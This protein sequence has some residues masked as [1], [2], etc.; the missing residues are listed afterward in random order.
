M[1]ELLKILIVFVFLLLLI[2]KKIP[3]GYTLLL[4]A[5]F[6]GILFSLPVLVLIENLFKATIEWETLRLLFIVILVTIF[7][8]VLRYTRSLRDLTD[9]LESLIQDTRVILMLLPALI[10]ILPMPG[11]AMMSA[12]MVEE[13]GSRKKL[14]PEIKAAFNHWFRHILEFVFPLYQGVIIAS[15]ILKVPLSKIILA[16][17]PMSLT[18]LGAGMV[19]LFCKIKVEKE[20]DKI[21]KK[22]EENLFLFLKSI[23]GVLLAVILNLFLG[24]DLLWALLLSISFF[25]I[26]NRIKLSAFFKIIRENVTWD[27]VMLIL[28]IM[29]FKKIIEVSGAVTVVPQ[30]LSTWGVSPVLVICLVPFA[31]GALTGVTTAF[32]GISYPIL[33]SF[34]KPDGVHFGYAML[35]YAAGFTGVMLSPVHLCLVL[36]KDYF[37]ASFSKIY[38]LIIPPSIILIIVALLL[39]L[40]GYPWGKIG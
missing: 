22:I 27:I 19:F 33:L 16:Q 9:S 17:V 14:S 24:I 10:G 28:G 36:T 4:G 39:V 38:K 13:V 34:L 20:K 26:L 31:V 35:A 15:V 8:G 12:P 2:K 40:L 5:I 30:T 23:W 37:K 21:P 6:L 11:G 1:I 29:I 25:S 32:I 3:I 18:M 7:G